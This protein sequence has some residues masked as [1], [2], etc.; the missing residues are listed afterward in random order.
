MNKIYIFGDSYADKNYRFDETNY[1]C[2]HELLQEYFID[3]DIENYGRISAGPHYS[4]KKLYDIFFERNELSKNDVIIFILSGYDRIDYPDLGPYN[5]SNI[6]WRYLDKELFC[7][8]MSNLETKS[9][10]QK[11]KDKIEFACR[12]FEEEMEYS[13]AKNEAFLYY[14]TKTVKC[15]VLLFYKSD[16][17]KFFS[18]NLNDKNFFKCPIS[19]IDVSNNEIKKSEKEYWENPEKIF[20]SRLD[21]RANHLSKENHQVLSNLICDFIDYGKSVFTFKR[22]IKTIDECYRQNNLGDMKLNTGTDFIYE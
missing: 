9:Y 6:K 11:N 14:L 15:K 8:D 22:Y 20:S 3:Y 5:S 1:K 4:F 21:Y 19:L 16:H 2:W 17:D 7:H 10:F 12:T 13:N 18:K